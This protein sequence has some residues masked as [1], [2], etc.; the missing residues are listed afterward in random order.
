M[1]EYGKRFLTSL[2]L[3]SGGFASLTHHLLI[4]GFTWQLE[5]YCHGLWGLIAIII[6]FILGIK[7]RKEA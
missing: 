6:G 2:I 1:K 7:K 3:I 5:W 4:H